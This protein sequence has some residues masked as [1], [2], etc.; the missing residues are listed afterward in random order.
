[1]AKIDRSFVA[2]VARSTQDA[3]LV[4]MV[5]EAA[6]SFG[7]QV[8]AEGVEDADQARQLVAM[9]CDTA[10]GWYFGR[11]VPLA[12]HLAD[13]AGGRSVPLG[14][15][16]LAG[17]PI[18]LGAA[19]AMVMV[20]DPEGI[21]MYASSTSTLL[22]G[23]TPQQLVG[24]AATDYV[25][26][27]VLADTSRP[28]LAPLGSGV[29]TYRLQHRDG[30]DR[31]VEIDS[32]GLRGDDG[33]LLEVISVCHDVTEATRARD[34]LDASE[35]RFRHIFDTAP[36]GMALSS[37]DGRIWRVNDVY[38][39]ML[40][41]EPDALV[42]R[43]VAELTHPDDRGPDQANLSALRS[44]HA[45]QHEVVKRYL[46]AD[47]GSVPVVVH[48]SLVDAAGS[49]EGYVMAHIVQAGPVQSADRP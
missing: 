16:P 20:T 27:E 35:D 15:D 29:V 30:S 39:H 1:M 45:E 19:D 26:P 21:I 28:A 36:I 31:F 22:I 47:G 46:H 18:P 25:H 4:R 43:A 9:G 2:N 44:G 32:R 7:L 3:V 8:C 34:A 38:A 10:Q 11:P 6:H 5:I 41:Y 14:S 24:T 48:A 40:G 12:Q 17:P 49:R 37:L 13:A 33:T 23:W 42:G